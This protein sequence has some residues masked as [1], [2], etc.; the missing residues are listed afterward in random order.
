VVFP[1]PRIVEL[2]AKVDEVD[3]RRQNSLAA[4]VREWLQRTELSPLRSRNKG[5]GLRAQAIASGDMRKLR[6]EVISHGAQLNKKYPGGDDTL[7]HI[8]CRE[9]YLRMVEFMLENKGVIKVNA[10]NAKKRTPLHLVFSS[11]QL[12]YCGSTFGIED[13]LLRLDTTGHSGGP[14]EDRGTFIK[15]WS[16]SI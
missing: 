9:G 8:V 7:L 10:E 13:G 14:P 1:E 4:S 2:Q 3:L 16:R 12:T 6:E 5:P 11:P 15:K